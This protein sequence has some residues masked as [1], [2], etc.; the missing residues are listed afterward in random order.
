MKEYGYDGK[1]VFEGEYLN[2]KKNGIGKEYKMN[3]TIEFEGEYLNGK[4]RKGKVYDYESNLKF[5]GEYLNGKKYGI[6]KSYYYDYKYK[7]KGEFLDGIVKTYGQKTELLDD[8]V[9]FI[10][11]YINGW[12]NGKLETFNIFGIKL[13]E[14]EYLNGKIWNGKG[15]I[16]TN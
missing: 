12:E 16:I 10:T 8:P 9:I 5:E 13:F 14:G 11:K 4:R 7:F 3:G 15:G 6:C 1:L 2:G